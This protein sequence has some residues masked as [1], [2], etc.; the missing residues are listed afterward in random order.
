MALT[1]Y[2]LQI[3]GVAILIVLGVATLWWIAR[4]V[5]GRLRG[6]PIYMLPD[7]D[8]DAHDDDEAD[9]AR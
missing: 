8:P 1:P 7:T 6:R 9:D 3:I 4:I 2:Q 5:I